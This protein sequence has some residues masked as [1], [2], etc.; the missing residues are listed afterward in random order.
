MSN[1][2]PTK[3]VRGKGKNPAKVHVNLRVPTEVME[4]YKGFPNYTGKMREVLVNYQKEHDHEK[5]SS[6]SLR[7][8]DEQ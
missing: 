6:D 8:D 1:E 3:R 4:F 7:D 5:V 2:M